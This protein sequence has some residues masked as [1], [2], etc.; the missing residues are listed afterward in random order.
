LTLYPL[1]A[2]KLYQHIHEDFFQ[3]KSKSAANNLMVWGKLSSEIGYL[4][5]LATM[6][7]YAPFNL[8]HVTLIGERSRGVLSDM[9]LKQLPNGWAV[10]MSNEIYRAAAGNVYEGVGISKQIEPQVFHQTD[11]YAGLIKTVDTAHVF[12]TRKAH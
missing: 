9:L 12:L 4:A 11:F 5:T 7:F 2:Q 3:G 6:I 8:P 1:G 10:S